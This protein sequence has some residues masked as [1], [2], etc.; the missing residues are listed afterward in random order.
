MKSTRRI[1]MLPVHV[2]LHLPRYV[3]LYRAHFGGNIIGT[4]GYS[5]L[6]SH[7]RRDGNGLLNIHKSY[8]NVKVNTSYELVKFCL[9]L[10]STDLKSKGACTKPLSI[11]GERPKLPA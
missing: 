5:I 6:G 2:S 9:L 10:L 1:K 8:L 4:S 3:F 11:F 7:E